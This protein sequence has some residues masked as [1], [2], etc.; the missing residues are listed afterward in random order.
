MRQ[1]IRPREMAK[2]LKVNYWTVLRWAAEGRIPCVRIGRLVRF[3]P[4]EVFEHLR[5]Q[6]APRAADEAHEEE[7]SS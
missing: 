1:V 3:D 4:V 5:E 7:P 2:A 6:S